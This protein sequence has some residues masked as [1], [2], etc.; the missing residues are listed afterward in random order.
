[1]RIISRPPIDEF[2]RKHATAIIPLNDWYKKTQQAKCENWNELKEVF[3]AC[4]NVGNN[5]YVFNIGGNNFRLVAII[6]FRRQW[7]YIRAILT[8]VEYDDHNKRGTLVTL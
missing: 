1:M 4:D 6:N 8:H 5:R 3:S 7:L 2:G